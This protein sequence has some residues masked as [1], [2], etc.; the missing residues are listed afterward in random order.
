MRRSTRTTQAI[1][2]LEDNIAER[3]GLESVMESGDVSKIA[4]DVSHDVYGDILTGKA[5]LADICGD[6]IT[7]VLSDLATPF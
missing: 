7:D 5:G 4:A 6:I 1:N 2:Q 3:L